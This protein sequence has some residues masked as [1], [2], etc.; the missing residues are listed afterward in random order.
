[1]EL[2]SLIQWAL[3]LVIVV[4]S[5]AWGRTASKI[6]KNNDATAVLGAQIAELR[7]RVGAQEGSLSDCKN[8]VDRAHRRIGGVGRVTDE[9]AGRIQ[10]MSTTL[11][12]I[13]ERLLVPPDRQ[14][15]GM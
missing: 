2:S 12:T 1:M 10:Q 7:G 6:A 11:V 5:G 14:G 9:N 4:L 15:G 3:G 13:Q 8:Q